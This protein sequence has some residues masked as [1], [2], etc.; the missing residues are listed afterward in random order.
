M[1]MIEGLA[2]FPLTFD[3]HGKLESRQAL[4]GLIE[5]ASFR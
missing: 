5:H 4:D 2:F 1:Q 3:D